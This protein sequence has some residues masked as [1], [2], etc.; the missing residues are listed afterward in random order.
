MAGAVPDP[1]WSALWSDS[2]RALYSAQATLPPDWLARAETALATKSVPRFSLRQLFFRHNLLPWLPVLALVIAT[3]SLADDAGTSMPSPL[4]HPNAA[5][6]YRRGDFA[7]A[8]SGWRTDV[9]RDPLD[10]TARY[11]LSIALA[12]QNR[13]DEAAA[14]ASAAFAQEPDDPS[15]RWQFALACDKAGFAPDALAG[16]LAPEPLQWLA[17]LASPAVWQ[18]AA[19]A[20]AWL[21]AL[22]LGLFLV[23][24][25]GLSSRGW[26]AATAWS[27]LALALVVALAAG[28]GWHAYGTAADA[29]AA[30]IWRNA[31]LR[32]I[33]TEVDA[34]QKTTPLAAGSV[35]VAD[36]T[37][38][39]WVRLSFE[40]GQTGWV[41]REEAV[42]LW[43]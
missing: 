42:A 9:F 11:N 21:A 12:Q 1:A 35:G 8:E 4:S 10:W 34:P 3:S 27:A 7:A 23:R 31:T 33:P 20:S 29:D 43:K 25:Y 41:R 40:N 36:K 28:A 19:L 38:L 15:V 26:T 32:S 2:D 37:F 39:G 22:S 14:Q 17:R 13:W 30:I 16:F 6:A 18:R 5:S 24:G